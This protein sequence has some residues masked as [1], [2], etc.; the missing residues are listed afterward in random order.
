MSVLEGKE[1]QKVWHYFEEIC[2]IPHGSGNVEGISNYLVSFAKEHNLSCI[3]DEMKNIIIKKRACR[4]YEQEP[5]VILQG[6]M[7]MVAV[8]KPG[9]AIDMEKD[10]LTLGVEGDFL[11]AKDTSLG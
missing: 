7:D 1:P 2:K 4:G 9:A 8:K 3:Q 6:H 5:A 10:G 11:Y